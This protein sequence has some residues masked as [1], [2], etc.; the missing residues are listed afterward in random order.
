MFSKCL[1]HTLDSTF[2][3]AFQCSSD[4]LSFAQKNSEIVFPIPSCCFSSI[5]ESV[6]SFVKVF[7]TCRDW[8]DSPSWNNKN[9]IANMRN[10]DFSRNWTTDDKGQGSLQDVKQMTW[11]IGLPQPS[12]PRVSGLLPREGEPRSDL[13]DSLNWG[14]AE[15]CKT[16]VAEVWRTEI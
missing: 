7:K 13:K 4:M 11:A 6:R 12:A 3:S 9:Q 8:I 16:N 1:T 10:N 5:Q 14:R 15:S 2:F